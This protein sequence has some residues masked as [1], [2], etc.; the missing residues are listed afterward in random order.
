MVKVLWALKTGQNFIGIQTNHH[1]TD[2]EMYDTLIELVKC[3]F[4]KVEV[5]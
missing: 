1:L 2:A 3:G 4:V 5:C